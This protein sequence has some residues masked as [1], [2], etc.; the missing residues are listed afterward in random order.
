MRADAP[1]DSSELARIAERFEVE[2]DYRSP[3]IAFEEAQQV[4]RTHVE[5]VSHRHET[6]QSEP[7]GTGLLGEH[8]A[9]RA[10]LGHEGETPRQRVETRERRVHSNERIRVH[11]AETIRSD[12]THPVATGDLQEFRLGVRSRPTGFREPRSNHRHGAD[13][14]GRGLGEDI[15]DA[16]RR[17]RDDCEIDAFGNQR[18]RPV[19]L[20]AAD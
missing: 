15:G 3:L 5:L 7:G 12:D 6:R 19:G 10:G 17:H 18:E 2:R 9:Y 4:V 11:E 20:D 8:N 14:R 16:I 13:T 1:S